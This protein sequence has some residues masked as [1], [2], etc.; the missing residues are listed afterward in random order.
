[1]S[2][3][4]D[5][6]FINEAYQKMLAEKKD[7]TSFANL[8]KKGISFYL[9]AAAKRKEIDASRTATKENGSKYSQSYLTELMNKHDSDLTESVTKIQSDFESVVTDTI[10]AK[11]KK[12][13]EMLSTPPTQEQI[14]LL[15]ALEIRKNS[16]ETGEVERIALQ[17]L[18]NYNAVKALQD[19]VS[20]AGIHI[21]LPDHLDYSRLNESLNWVEKY[22]NERIHDLALPWNQMSPLGRLF[23]GTE[24]ADN[25]FG[26]RA[27][28]LDGSVQMS[29]VIEKTGL[30]EAET[31]MLENMFSDMTD[32]DISEKISTLSEKDD[33]I[34]NLVSLHPDYSK[35]LEKQ[36]DD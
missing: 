34:K 24:W 26:D 29:V 2:Y 36:G 12:L 22:L 5:K 19:I 3:E 35:F 27:E 33:V 14:N 30:T 32:E 23:F 10:S 20:G 21:S 4:E 18:D 16:L 31:A 7:D 1:M 28:L 11:R 25:L 13:D 8:R 6:C 15:K 9:S 17:L